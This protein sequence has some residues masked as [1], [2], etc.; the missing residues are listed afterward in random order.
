VTPCSH[1]AIQNDTLRPIF[2]RP[3]YL[4]DL[5]KAEP[6][7]SNDVELRGAV[8]GELL[9]QAYTPLFEFDVN[10]HA[11]A[12]LLSLGVALWYSVE[13]DRTGA[14]PTHCITSA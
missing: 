8:N 4:T 13:S 2:C 14:R 11:C 9:D 5:T 3:H 10:L 12:L 6:A 7:Q 1:A